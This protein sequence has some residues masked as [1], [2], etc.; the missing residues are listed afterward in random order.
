MCMP[1]QSGTSYYSTYMGWLSL[2]SRIQA[3]TLSHGCEPA[4]PAYIYYIL[5]SI[6]IYRLGWRRLATTL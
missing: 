2:L 4:T 3:P 5:R 6:Y 1:G